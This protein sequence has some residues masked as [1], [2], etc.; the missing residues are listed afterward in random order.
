[1]TSRGGD[2]PTDILCCFGA[3]CLGDPLLSRNGETLIVLL[4]SRRGDVSGLKSRLELFPFRT[5]LGGEGP[6]A[7]SCLSFNFSLRLLLFCSRVGVTSRFIDFFEVLPSR[8]GDGPHPV[9][10][11]SFFDFVLG[12]STSESNVFFLIITIIGYYHHHRT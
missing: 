9:D 1:M 5:S 10:V 4:V 2:G 6:T 8:G 11:R 7:I 3:S 12:F